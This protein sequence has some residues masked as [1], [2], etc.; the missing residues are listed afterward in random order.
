MNT[1]TSVVKPEVTLMDDIFEEFSSGQLR[2]PGFQRP[3]VWEPSDMLDLFDSLYNG[4]PIGSLLLWETSEKIKSG[5]QVGAIKIPDANNGLVTYVLDG[6]QRLATLYSCLKLAKD[7]PLTKK[8]EDWRWWI[9][10]DLRNDNFIHVKTEKHEPWL[11]PVRAIYQTMDFLNQARHIQEKC[12][13]DAPVLIEK[14]ERLSQKIRSY[15]I[16]IIRVRGSSLAHAVD[17]F[18]RLNRKG[19]KITP[20]Q[21][22]SA[23]TYR[24]KE[25]GK[26]LEE[27]IDEILESLTD[28]HFNN[29][30]RMTIFRAIMAAADTKVHRSDWENIAKK[31][32]QDNLS[33]AVQKAGNALQ[34]AAAFLNKEIGLPGDK[35]LPYTNQLL[36]LNEFFRH[37]PKP[38][39]AQK[40]ILKKWF[41]VSSLSDWLTSINTTQ[42]NQALEDMQKFAEDDSFELKL[43]SGKPVA[44]AFPQQFSSSKSSR[45]RA[46]FIFMLT[47]RPLDLITGEPIDSYKILSENG[48]NAFAYIF[49]RLS[50]SPANRLLLERIPRQSIRERLLSIPEPKQEQ[51]LNS[52]GIPTKAYQALKEDD[53]ETFIELRTQHL[54]ELEE[55]FLQQFGITLS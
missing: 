15:K 41:W 50:S 11:F 3:F 17:I 44:Q 8:L 29:I 54:M 33:V 1:N 20:D 40:K 27:Y 35:L 55:N 47:K 12:K 32:S 25:N 46:F 14:A 26:S 22:V 43:M 24:D 37:C 2:I 36:L 23:L 30:N 45:F 49:P 42:L 7:F 31:I 9:W 21:M 18:S 51:I 38:K 10:F 39:P 6:Q 16:A 48:K 5:Q 53:A 4:Y 19:Q 13:E 52:H 34:T 28:Y